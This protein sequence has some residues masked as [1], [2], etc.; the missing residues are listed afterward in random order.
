MP[1]YKRSPCLYYIK[2][3]AFRQALFGKFVKN[4]HCGQIRNHNF[5]KLDGKYTIRNRKTVAIYAISYEK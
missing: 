4:Q 3:L 5:V 1:N 2:V